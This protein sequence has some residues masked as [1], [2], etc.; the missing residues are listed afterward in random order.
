MTNALTMFY[1]VFIDTA[2]KCVIITSACIYILCKHHLL[3]GSNRPINVST[4]G[5]LVISLVSVHATRYILLLLTNKNMLPEL[6]T[7]KYIH[8]P[9]KKL[10]CYIYI[11]ITQ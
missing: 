2:I 7:Y 11:I 3:L 10:H 9:A 4:G 1:Y 8:Y 6:N 5:V